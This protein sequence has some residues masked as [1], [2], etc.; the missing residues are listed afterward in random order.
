MKFCRSIF[1]LG[2]L[3][4]LAAPALS[5]TAQGPMRMKTPGFSAVFSG[6]W[7]LEWNADKTTITAHAGEYD[8][9]MIIIYSRFLPDSPSPEEKKAF[10]TFR[11][12]N[13]IDV[14]LSGEKLK[15]FVAHSTWRSESRTAKMDGGKS[16]DKL[17][18]ESAAPDDGQRK[19]CV[20]LR[21]YHSPKAE[22]YYAQIEPGTCEQTKHFFFEVATRMEWK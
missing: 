1:F 6:R 19:V 9:P 8:L 14:V 16:V 11:D 22:V 4:L 10:E 20:F 5:E 13:K 3:M 2:T 12:M 21:T 7:K 17:D 18:I 15:D